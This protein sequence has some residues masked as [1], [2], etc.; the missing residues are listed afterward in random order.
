MRLRGHGKTTSAL[1]GLVLII[2][3]RGCGLVSR[4]NLEDL[5]AAE[6]EV[7]CRSAFVGRVIKGNTPTRVLGVI[8]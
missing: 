8:V 2:D 1:F 3:E 4:S 5:S 6:N 7:L